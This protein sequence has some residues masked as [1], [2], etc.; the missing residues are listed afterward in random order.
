MNNDIEINK[1]NL[2]SNMNEINRMKSN[3]YT[4]QNARY[5]IDNFFIYDIDI[6]NTY[7]LTRTNPKFLLFSYS[8]EDDFKIGSYLEINC[9]MEYK[10]Q[11]Y[12]HIGTLK[13]IFYFYDENNDLIKKFESKKVNSGDNRVEN[14]KQMD[15]FYDN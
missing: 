13:H 8:M 6:E 15:L 11:N 12:Q 2:E 14:L 10:Y 4:V 7:I 3:L 5:S 1:G 9:S